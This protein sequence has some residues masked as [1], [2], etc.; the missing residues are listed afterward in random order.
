MSTMF[1]I[2]FNPGGGGRLLFL[3][4]GPRGPP[5]ERK[6]ELVLKLGYNRMDIWNLGEFAW[7]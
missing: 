7:A 4:P 1:V 5:P 2:K 3:G 6:N